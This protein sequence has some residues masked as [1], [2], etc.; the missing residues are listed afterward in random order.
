MSSFH[1]GIDGQVVIPGTSTYD[2]GTTNFNI[3]N[4]PSHNRPTRP[5][6]PF[7]TVPFPPD[8]DFVDRPEILVWVRD[9][10]AGPGARAGLVGLG[11]V[12]KSQLAIQ[13]AHSIRDARPQTFVF[14]VHASTRARFE[15]AY[16]DIADW[17]QLPGRSDP[18]ANV[19]RLV[20]NWLQDEANGTWLLI[21]DNVDDVD[22]FYPK[23]A[24][25]SDRFGSPSTSLAEY[26][27]Q[28]RNGSILITSRNK[29]AAARLAGGYPRIKGVTALSEHQA[30]Q[31]LRN[32]L[33]NESD[34]EGAV[35]LLRTL[36]YLPLAITQAAAYINR[37][38]PQVTIQN[39][40]NK[41]HRSIKNRESLL[42]QDAGDLRR[43]RSASSSVVAT[44]QLTFKRVRKERRS[45]ADLL[46]L[47]SFFNP[48]AIPEFALRSFDSG[49]KTR[50]RNVKDMF[51]V[52]Q[53]LK[54]QH[55]GDGEKDFYDDIGMLQA[56]SL[57]STTAE[58][59]MLKMHPLV[60][61]CTIAWLSS[62][63]QAERFR[64][65]F[66]D[67]MKKTFLSQ[68]LGDWEKC[69]Q[70]VPH[71]DTF[72]PGEP[73]DKSFN[74]WVSLTIDIGELL[75]N[76]GKYNEAVMFYRRAL[77][78]RE[79]ELGIQH[80][81]TLTRVSDLASVLLYQGKY[82]EAEKLNRRA[83]EG[84][85]KELGIQHPH[86]LLSVSNLSVVLAH[87]GK[88]DE[89]EKL[90]QR[91]LEG[92]EKELGIQHPYTLTSVGNLALVLAH[93]GKYDE[94]E[95][96]N[97]RALEGREKEL[98]VQ[99]PG[100]LISVGNLAL[101]LLYQGKYN[102]TEQ[103]NRRA[104]EGREKELG[105][106]HP[107]TLFSVNNLA[108]VLRAQGKYDEAEK[109]NRQ[110]LEGREKE[111]GTQHPD[112]LL[113]VSSLAIVL[114]HQ[115][116]YD[117]AEKLNRRALEGLE[118]ELG[119]Q[120]PHTLFS[121]NNLAVVLRAQGKYD[122][123]EK[124]NRQALE[125]REKELGTQ[126]PDTL[127]SV[128]SLAIVLEHQGK[129]DEAE[130][131]N[132]RALEGLEKELGIQ[133]PHTLLSMNNLAVVLRDQRKY[134]EAEQL[135]RQALEGREKE[136]GIQHPD[137]LTSMDHL[138]VVL[139]DQRKY[140]EAE[141]L[142]RQALEGRE[143]ALGTQHPDTLT[144]VYSSAHLLHR[145]RRYTEAAELYQQAYGGYAQQ[146]GS[147]HPTT[148]ACHEHFAAMQQEIEHGKPRPSDNVSLAE[149]ECSGEPPYEASHDQISEVQ[150]DR[151]VR[152]S[153]VQDPETDYG[154]HCNIPL[155][156]HPV[157]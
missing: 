5:R 47:M 152:I 21:L 105:I 53:Y 61:H 93:Q 126:H 100:T 131:L 111:L 109:L 141:Q 19:L 125:G 86:T 2:G 80:P 135:N 34:S 57:I 92:L 83:L 149:R 136:L 115:G 68:K 74:Q 71:I 9:K 145:L 4:P 150:M 114:E 127:L 42:N 24:H 99:H 26:V 117:E 97:R 137:T 45:A 144:S 148:V 112:T 40:L 67:L 18:K 62:A 48:Q 155:S 101:V 90:N 3:Y 138:A 89:A 129:Y 51:S 49:T 22:M 30:L 36:G 107:H 65:V 13:Y 78:G 54:N 116:K 113:S 120:H 119:I 39:Y 1:A 96:L 7:S 154:W 139:R 63:R 12:G 64:V 143:K 72:D 79:K 8:P 20:R 32:K 121:V 38:A 25:A 70:L 122:E 44:W 69:K 37:H 133:H 15:E 16:Q 10:C 91:A 35:Q 11:G 73:S 41:F 76:R 82:D 106:Q 33:H 52:P 151:A 77:E 31:L 146:L 156:E 130:K 108:V 103:L 157:V 55:K 132:R 128:S 75:Y 98:G 60:Q 94:A 118:K 124:L 134:K 88:Y 43:D 104:L 102:E 153:A 110:A 84:R 50:M 142:N 28:C 95:K 81:D 23:Q 123:A 147:Q 27:P 6:E 85:E 58:K 140:K 14:W 87:Q 59:E 29:D 56:Y 17:L 46:L 66:L